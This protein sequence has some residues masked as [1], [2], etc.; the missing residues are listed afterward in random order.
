MPIHTAASWLTTRTGGGILKYTLMAAALFLFLFGVI[1][2]LGRTRVLDDAIY[3]DI[4]IEGAGATNPPPGVYRHPLGREVYVSA[5]PTPNSGQGFVGWRGD[6]VSDDYQINFE[7]DRHKR[8]TAVFAPPETADRHYR[9]AA[10]IVAGPGAGR[11]EPP[12][13][14]YCFRE[15]ERRM[16]KALTGPSAFFNG[17]Q[18]V[19]EADAGNTPALGARLYAPDIAL[20][21]TRDYIVLAWFEDAG[22]VL[23]LAQTGPGNLMWPSG[24]Y[25][26]AHGAP[27]HIRVFPEEGCR[28][29][30]WE[31]EHGAVV[32]APGPDSDGELYIELTEDTTRRAVF[33][34]AR[35]ALSLVVE[36][37]GTVFTH[38]E[39]SASGEERAY[40]Y[41]A[42]VMVIAQPNDGQT[43]FAGW[44]GDVPEGISNAAQ[45]AP[46]LPLLMIDNRRLVARFV[47]AETT[48]QL[49]SLV[50]GKSDTRTATLLTPGPGTFGFVRDTDARAFLEALL[51]PNAPLAFVGWSG[52]LPENTCATARRLILP[53]DRDR[54]VTA[55]FQEQGSRHVTVSVSGP[56]AV[57]P[58]PGAYTIAPNHAL[59]LEA[60]PAP[61]MHFGGWRIRA[62]DNDAQTVIDNPL[63]FHVAENAGIEAR[64]GE[65]AHFIAIES[66]HDDA[67]LVPPPGYY[68]LA[69]GTIL[70]LRAAPPE[71]W[72]F[73]YWEDIDGKR[74]STD[75]T[76]RVSITGFQRCRAIFGPP[77]NRL[78]LETGGE[79]A[80]TIVAPHEQ[81]QTLFAP[82]HRIELHARPDADSVFTHWE[83]DVPDTANAAAPVLAVAMD[84]D[85]TIKAVFD[86][87]DYQVRIAVEGLGAESLASISP[88]PGVYGMRADTELSLAAWP[89]V[90]SEIAF[91]GWRGALNTFDPQITARVDRDLDLTACFAH[92]D[93]VD[94]MPLTVLPLEGDGEGRLSPLS[95]GVYYFHRGARLDI[96][97]HPDSHSFFGGWT[98]DYASHMDYRSLSVTLDAAREIG[99]CVAGKGAVLTLL[100]EGSEGG[101]TD[102]PPQAYRFAAGMAVTM[103]ARRTNTK[104]AFKGWFNPLGGCYSTYGRYTLI[105]PDH[106]TAITVLA[107]FQRQ[108]EIPELHLCSARHLSKQ[109]M[110]DQ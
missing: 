8:I 51:T 20:H 45:L 32:H 14:R 70:D 13:G 68:E 66:N 27:V 21:M 6:V 80:G 11:L 54:R 15:S 41:G 12:Q 26:L 77:R 94:A 72:E 58:P 61:G 65:Q 59:V 60:T 67:T 17:W 22:H 46:E 52:D 23:S 75:R 78:C 25:A 69:E 10:V 42:A 90:D 40:P 5:V 7:L 38:P 73:Y 16:F 9:T 36:G 2:I 108:Y 92:R 81:E 49:E 74:F 82:D 44:H 55:L 95:P 103:T 93:S 24:D 86:K 39:G 18:F 100:V 109:G 88:A 99:A 43:A 1:F 79:G 107:R 64:F 4:V 37:P 84:R 91:I 101:A 53:M 110:V 62:D 19:E 48:L 50:D 106:E 97:L 31:D 63:T 96:S 57:S 85:R 87:A 34:P 3:L 89:R 71:G 30:H 98:G 47:A 76:I 56:G 29:R 28:L 33:E 104:Y 105:M 83:G 102:P 35:R